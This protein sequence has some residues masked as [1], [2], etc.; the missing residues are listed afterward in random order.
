MTELPTLAVVGASGAV[1]TVMCE[2]LSARK[3]VWGEIRLVASPR[4]AG[5][6]IVVRGEALT[7]EALSPEVFD[8]VDVAMFDV[9][10]EVAA[11]WAPIAAARGAVCVDNS[12]AFRMDP[13]VPLV[14]PEVNPEQIRHRPKGIISNPNCTTLAMIVAMGALHQE[15][16]LRELIV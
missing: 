4:S 15:Y 6:T 5:K 11:Q 2:L 7:V 16:G 3:N 9:P 10:D 8:G 1:G 12:G 13:D 14:V